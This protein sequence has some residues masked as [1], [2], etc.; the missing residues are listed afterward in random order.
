MVNQGDTTKA[1]VAVRRALAIDSKSPEVYNMM[2]YIYAM[3]GDFE[4]ALSSYREAMDLDEFYIDPLIN[5]IELLTHPDADPEEAFRLCGI[6]KELVSDRRELVDVALLESDA[7][8]NLHRLDEALQCLRGIASDD[9][10][11]PIHTLLLGRAFYESGAILEARRFIDLAVRRDPDNP[12]AWYYQGL[13]A[14]D[15]GRRIDAVSSFSRVLKLDGELPEPPWA[16]KF[17]SVEALVA[18]AIP[19]LDDDVQRMFREVNILIETAPSESQIRAEVDPRQV[20][21]LE[22][23]NPERGTFE[24]MW[25]FTRNLMRTGVMS[26]TIEFEIA[27]MIRHEANPEQDGG[28]SQFV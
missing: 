3:E 2:G 16:K 9:E 28:N 4:E 12:D 14:R 22:G 27:L 5:S 1:L 24:K 7:L 20:I 8:L 15:D 6:A 18:R 13:I 17:G 11:S 26:S 25:V 21:F 19:L 23:I 10:L